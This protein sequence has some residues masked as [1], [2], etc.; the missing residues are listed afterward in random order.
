M[1]EDRESTLE[2][3]RIAIQLEKEG[4]KLFSEAAGRVTGRH[5]RQTFEFLMAEEDKHIK[6]IQEFYESIERSGGEDAK[7]MDEKEAQRNLDAFNAR[8]A[9]LSEELEPSSSDIEA[10]NF[11]L[12]FEN[13][14]E[15]F[16]SEKMQETDNPH[17]KQFY[18]WLI[19]EEEMHAKLLESCLRFA[20]DPAGWFKDQSS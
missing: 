15:E 9:Q 16:Y 11:A 7:P 12:K 18:R 17:V 4:K 6:R 5:A 19:A 1:S 13:G 10:Y 14:A 2:P 20:E 8:M 3:L